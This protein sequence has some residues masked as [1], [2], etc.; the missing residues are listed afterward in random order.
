[1][2]FS[3]NMLNL[4]TLSSCIFCV[5][6]YCLTASH[7][8]KPKMN[9]YLFCVLGAIIVGTSTWG[10]FQLGNEV[11]AYLI[12]ISIEIIFYKFFT[13]ITWI[14]AT[15]LGLT[16][17]FHTI[18]IKGITV[19]IFSFMLKKN[20]YQVITNSDWS[21]MVLTATMLIKIVFLSYHFKQ[22]TRKKLRTLFLSE[23]E[24]ISVLC[25]HG[26]LFIFM[27][28]YSYNYYYNLDLVWFSFAQMLLSTL[29]LVLY[30]LILNYGIRVSHLLEN[31]LYRDIISKQLKTQLSQYQSYKDTLSKIELFRQTYQET[32]LKIQRLMDSNDTRAMKSLFHNTFANLIE[33]LPKRREYSNTEM[34]NAFIFEWDNECSSSGITLEALIH[35]PDEFIS[36][37]ENIL[38]LLFEVHDIYTTLASPLAVSKIKVE[39][40]T[41]D[42]HFS[43]YIEGPFKGIIESKGDMPYFVTKDALK[44]KSSYHRISNLAND[45]N[46]KILWKAKDATSIFNLTISIPK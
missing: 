4:I 38:Q 30:Y 7:Y 25:Q 39:S 21:M 5:F 42:S 26:A 37:Q 36:R 19:G 35:I 43:L 31:E 14:Q 10:G 29:M 13:H 28:F 16:S 2:N 11:A 27:L 6:L 12:I 40:K 44:I 18:C 41:T 32:E 17:I 8:W 45:L 9:K 34:L 3:S 33:Q 20:L 15:F 22:T 46:G 24:L 23:E 1:M